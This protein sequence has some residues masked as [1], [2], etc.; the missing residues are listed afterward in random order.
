MI[1]FYTAAHSGFALEKVPL[2]GGGTIAA[3]L[4]QEWLRTKPFTLQMLRPD[5]LGAEAPQHKDLVQYSELE[6][7]RFCRRFEKATT[8]VLL[9]Q[10]PKESIVLCNDISEGPDFAALAKAGFP[11]FTIY[12]VDVV[13]Y[14][15]RMYLHQW[16]KPETATRFYDHWMCS[17][18]R[19][20]I[21]DLL[22]LVFQK[23]ADSVYFSRGLIVMSNAMK[24]TLIRCY[25]DVN[26]EKI[27][28]FPWG[29]P[30]QSIAFSTL[31]AARQELEARYPVPKESPVLISLS[32]ITPEKGQ[33]RLLK[34]L[35]LW[36]TKVDYPKAGVTYFLIGEAAYMQGKRFETRLRKLA[37]RL[38]RTR[39]Y[40][41]GFLS[42]A[43]KQAAL[44]RGD[45]Y[46]FPS[47]HESYGLTLLE[48][49][50]AGL[51]VLATPTY[52]VLD[53]LKPDFGTLL[54]STEDS[55]VPE[56]LQKSLSALFAHPDRLA[57]QGRAAQAFA[58][59]Q[60]FSETAAR[61][62]DWLIH[63]TDK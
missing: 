6:Y 22:K 9:K 17:P 32:R 30:E 23:Q 50:R 27:A 33:D 63:Q 8:E 31:N 7:A 18:F 38:K 61:L 29:L 44:E 41:T 11:V 3:W 59:T 12:H 4:E 56:L 1:L 49:M 13:D 14:F 35:A 39:V 25:P 62:A 34:A 26:P 58:Q 15:C 47:R 51:P 5:L 48:A 40:F 10:N 28:V 55:Q 45:L 16:I 20:L 37:S 42:G 24:E 2:G 60:R 19:F 46:V 21:P 53:I 43:S 54:S 57:Q 36:E 52:G